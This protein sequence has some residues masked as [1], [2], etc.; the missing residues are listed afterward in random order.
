MLWFQSNTGLVLSVAGEWTG[1]EDLTCRTRVCTVGGL[2]PRDM[3]RRGLAHE[4]QGTR[5]CARATSHALQGVNK[6]NAHQRFS[7]LQVTRI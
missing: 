1:T 7:Q 5:F 4:A 6:H 2:S 3:W